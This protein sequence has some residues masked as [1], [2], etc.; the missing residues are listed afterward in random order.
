LPNFA[1]SFATGSNLNVAEFNPA[2]IPGNPPAKKPTTLEVEKETE[3]KIG[4][5]APKGDGHQAVGGQ[6]AL[7]KARELPK[8]TF[9]AS[10]SLQPGGQISE[11]SDIL[12]FVH[13][14]GAVSSDLDRGGDP[15]RTIF[16]ESNPAKGFAKSGESLTFACS[17]TPPM[18]AT[19]HMNIS[20]SRL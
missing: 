7:D 13:L 20:F 19:L 1:E 3:S 11:K 6:R 8:G 5:V 9:E 17:D 14:F 2:N 15:A 16:V 12:T 18:I 4:T 10:C